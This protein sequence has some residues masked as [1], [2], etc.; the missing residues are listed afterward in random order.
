MPAISIGLNSQ[1]LNP[2]FTR[3][4]NPWSKRRKVIALPPMSTTHIKTISGRCRGDLLALRCNVM[5]HI[6]AV[7]SILI[8][9]KRVDLYFRF[10]RSSAGKNSQSSANA[11]TDVALNVA[12]IKVY[13]GISSSN[14]WFRAPTQISNYI[15]IFVNDCFDILVYFIVPNTG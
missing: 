7:G 9:V 14:T 13:F 6:C 3:C 12:A 2:M 15:L 1:V 10:Y 4:S 8:A 5:S 11:N